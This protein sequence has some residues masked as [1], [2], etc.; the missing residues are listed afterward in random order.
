[1]AEPEAV[2]DRLGRR[3]ASDMADPG[4]GDERVGVHN[5]A[6]V[7]RI[8]VE[9]GGKRA[10]QREIVAGEAGRPGAG[11]ERRVLAE[12]D[13]PVE[14]PVAHRGGDRPGRGTDAGVVEGR[15]PGGGPSRG[16]HA[17]V[18]GEGHDVPPGAVETQAAQGGDAAAGSGGDPDDV[19]GE[20]RGP[21]DGVT[22]GGDDHPHGGGGRPERGERP[23]DGHGRVPRGDDDGQALRRR[24]ARHS[25]RSRL[26][27]GPKRYPTISPQAPTVRK[28]PTSGLTTRNRP[29]CRLFPKTVRATRAERRRGSAAEP[30]P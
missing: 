15:D 6:L 14:G 25:T 12:E 5:L 8:R 16:R 23:R 4:P 27:P 29:K 1:V 24:R 17:G 20:R 10:P 7:D 9:A 28:R 26:R 3:V 11:E 13:G 18:F 21:G 22:R 2:A 30:N 19:P